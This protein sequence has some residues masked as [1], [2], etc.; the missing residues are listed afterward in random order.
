MLLYQILEVAL[1]LN[2]IKKLINLDF[3]LKK[4]YTRLFS[5]LFNGLEKFFLMKMQIKKFHMSFFTLFLSV[6][7]E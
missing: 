6:F 7:L 1:L 3:K 4:V 5:S 2:R